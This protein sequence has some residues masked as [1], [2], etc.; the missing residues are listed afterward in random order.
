MS[1]ADISIK[2]SDTF[3]REVSL[4]L[5]KGASV[6]EVSLLERMVIGNAN[7]NSNSNYETKV[8]FLELEGNIDEKMLFLVLSTGV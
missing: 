4:K 2:Q 7:A 8:L 1:L 5:A 6:D 3:I